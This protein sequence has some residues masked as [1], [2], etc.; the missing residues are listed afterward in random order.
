MQGNPSF[1]SQSRSSIL[2]M[3]VSLHRRG[4]PISKGH[5]FSNSSGTKFG[6]LSQGKHV[7]VGL[8]V[9]CINVVYFHLCNC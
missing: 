9:L 1:S 4:K 5:K 7:P 2:L 3:N 8:E 6:A